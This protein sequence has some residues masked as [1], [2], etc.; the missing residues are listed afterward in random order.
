M[1][2]SVTRKL[3]EELRLLF[4]MLTS[5]SRKAYSA[6]RSDSHFFNPPLFSSSHNQGTLQASYAKLLGEFTA[7]FV[8]QIKNKSNSERYVVIS[9]INEREVEILDCDEVLV[10]TKSD[11]LKIWTGIIMRINPNGEISRKDY[12]LRSALVL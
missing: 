3:N 9:N 6:Y 11:F 7:P 12:L 8:A 2:T 10:K 4:D 1:S 5:G